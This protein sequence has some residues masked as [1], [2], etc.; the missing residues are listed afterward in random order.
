MAAA[1]SAQPPMRATEPREAKRQAPVAGFI[2]M[3]SMAR[4][5]GLHRDGWE[6]RLDLGGG[7]VLQL[8]RD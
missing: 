8:V 3:D 5:P 1:L 7:V 2:E 6:V 4:R